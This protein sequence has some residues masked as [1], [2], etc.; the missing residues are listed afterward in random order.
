MDFSFDLNLL[1][2]PH[3]LFAVF[4]LVQGILVLAQ[5]RDSGLNRSFFI[6]ELASFVWLFG[7]GLNYLAS[8]NT[9]A[10]FFSRIG[11]LGVAYI[12]ASTY[13][14]SVYYLGDERQKKAA[15]SGIIATFLYSLFIGTEYMATGV[16]EYPWGTYIELGP[17]G[18]GGLLLFLIFAP[19]FIRNFYLKYKETSTRHARQGR[20]G[21]FALVTGALAFLAVTDFLPGFGVRLG[22]PPMGFLFVGTLATSM[23]YFI[24]RYRLV[25][26]EIVAGRGVGHFLMTALL[27]LGYGSI[28]VIV[29]PFE[30]T[31]EHIIFDAALFVAGLYLL[32]PLKE[33]TQRVV[34][35]L[36]AKE[37]LNFDRAISQFAA[38]LRNLS[39]IATLTAN[40]FIFLTEKLRIERSAVFLLESNEKQWT[41]FESASF[42]AGAYRHRDTILT[43]TDASSV[44]KMVRTI[45]TRGFADPELSGHPLLS[46]VLSIIQERKETLAFPLV[47][48]GVFLGFLSIGPRLSQKDFTSIELAAFE[49]LSSSLAIALE[50]ARAYETLQLSSKSKND[51]V[52]IIS[53]Q[54]RTPLTNIKWVTETLLKSA[55][56]LSPDARSLLERANKSA[57]A[58]VRLIGQ[59]LDTV[60][61][62]REQSSVPFTPPEKLLRIVEDVA[63]EYQLV[64]ERKGINLTRLLP[65]ELRVSVRAN[66]VYL[67][68]ILSVLLDNAARYTPERGT[69]NLQISLQDDARLQF[70]IT[71]NGIG[72]S[73]AEQGRVFEKFFRA[74]N[75]I[76]LVPDGTGLGLFYAKQLALAQGG[77][78]WFR[79]KEGQG[80]TFY[81]TLPLA[82][83]RE[84]S[85]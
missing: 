71:D 7:M 22:V 53:H 30:V 27:L 79:S 9:T 54:L 72:V 43:A 51:F 38:E 57:E 46:E 84:T 42:G 11:F 78:I 17:L 61:G 28:F 36:F 14:F 29:S 35:E 62:S 45:D 66:E 50:N 64:M 76:S 59:L 80:T 77:E 48:R 4:L 3:L 12:P 16:Y 81:F 2:L 63:N 15:F 19:L 69:V 70:A 18:I 10:T 24:L 39:D 32:S 47:L 44:S 23:G 41:F 83:K 49:R 21:Y 52:T 31:Y 6:F 13:L 67:R 58:M 56:K 74:N 33:R 26:I 60:S 82:G 1:A 8:D 65:R 40:L 68:A 37:R 34:D 73:E 5:N 25:D 85:G 55:A 20:W 75:A